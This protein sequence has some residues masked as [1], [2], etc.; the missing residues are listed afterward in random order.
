MGLL[1]ISAA[2]AAVPL[3]WPWLRESSGSVAVAA[4]T[5]LA[6]GL[7]ATAI[8]IAFGALTLGVAATALLLG[9]GRGNRDSLW[10]RPLAV[11]GVIASVEAL[12]LAVGLLPRRDLLVL[13]LLG[14]GVQAVAVGL[15]LER[16]AILSI[17]PPLISVAWIGI[18]ADSF[19][20]S[21]QWYTA[22]VALTLLAEVEVARWSSRRG[23]QMLGP[24][25]LLILEWA[26]IGLLSLSPLAEMFAGGVGFGLLAF[27]YSAALLIWGAMTRVRRRV[28]AAAVLASVTA[29]LT[30]SA[31]AAGE[32][33]PSAFFW[34]IAAGAGLALM[35]AIGIVEAYRSKSG[36]IMHRLEGLMEGWE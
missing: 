6:Y 5:A 34:I 1:A 7:E 33:P 9:F 25:Q 20:G 17:G 8:G 30:I 2:R 23:R 13:V 14:V 32:A 29:A 11:T 18:A 3:R 21:A 26:G 15:V 10:L 19:T 12:V 36:A 27:G 28:V 35:L 22:P 24:S 16:P 31:A 4:V